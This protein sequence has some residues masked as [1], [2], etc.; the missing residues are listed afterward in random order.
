ME[1]TNS[2]VERY[3][4]LK[5][6]S[7]IYNLSVPSL[8]ILLHVAKQRGIELPVRKRVKRQYLY[9]RIA[10]NNWLWEHAEKLKVDFHFT[11]KDK[12]EK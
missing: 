3:L 12:T 4:P 8:K 5:H 10:F 7:E 6:L 11:Q 2:F 9:D 1:K